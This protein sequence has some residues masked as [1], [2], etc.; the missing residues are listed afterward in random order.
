MISIESNYIYFF[1]CSSAKL[2][3]SVEAYFSPGER[4]SYHP[5]AGAIFDISFQSGSEGNIFLPAIYSDTALR[6]YDVRR[7]SNS[8]RIADVDII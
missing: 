8:E 7:P 6:I 5:A 2:I 1:M 3:R 4:Q